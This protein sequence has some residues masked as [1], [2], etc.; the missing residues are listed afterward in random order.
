MTTLSKY[1]IPANENVPYADVVFNCARALATM[2][3]SST[4]VCRNARK[5]VIKKLPLCPN[6]SA[7]NPEMGPPGLDIR[8]QSPPRSVPR[9][10]DNNITSSPH[11]NIILASDGESNTMETSVSRKRRLTH[12]DVSSERDDTSIDMAGSHARKRRGVIMTTDSNLISEE[13]RVVQ[14]LKFELSGNTTLVQEVVNGNRDALQ[15][16]WNLR[17][18]IVEDE[19]LQVVL[20]HGTMVYTCRSLMY[21]PSKC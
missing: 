9:D 21:L 3:V 17:W 14:R 11:H 8:Q 18:S 10:A 4:W 5:R 15:E 16:V 12:D 13:T 20:L 2:G 7:V 6:V 19:I 1:V